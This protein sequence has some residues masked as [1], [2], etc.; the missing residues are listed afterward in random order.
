MGYGHG[1]TATSRFRLWPGK[2]DAT[3]QA[4]TGIF[5]SRDDAKRSEGH[6]RAIGVP[7]DKV[8]LLTPGNLQK[9]L[10]S[11]P[12]DATEQ[13]GMGKAIGAVVGA[14][15][16]LTGGG[17]AMAALVPGVGP[18]SAVGLLGAAILGAA[19]ASIG[20]ATGASLENSTTD[21]LPEDEIFVYEDALRKGR[22]VVVALAAD[23]AAAS[24]LREQLKA[25]GAETIDAARQQWWIGLR[26][27]EQENYSRSGRN[28]RDDEKFYRLGFEEALHARTRCMEF[29]QVSAEMESNLED[30]QRQYPGVDVAEPFTRGYERGRNYYQHL[31]EESKAA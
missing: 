5:S 8:T 9:E 27:A 12:A 7:T 21:G 3:M 6:L 26:S 19:G 24:S 11:V 18:I 14:A 23:A 25:D 20:A 15:A 4:V 2:A 13:P 16:G 10:D 30:L 17:L 31:C 22:S 28:F 29:D 1:I